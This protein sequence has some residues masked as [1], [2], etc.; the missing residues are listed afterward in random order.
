MP[1]KGRGSPNQANV[2]HTTTGSKEARLSTWVGD[3]PRRDETYLKW[4]CE[5]NKIN[6]TAG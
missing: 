1:V 6:I 2:T 4:D 5:P 3:G